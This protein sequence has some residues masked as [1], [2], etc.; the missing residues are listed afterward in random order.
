M[1]H[2]VWIF[3]GILALLKQ[4]CP[5]NNLPA[6]HTGPSQLDQALA[7]EGGKSPKASQA[8][9]PAASTPGAH[10][11]HSK[12]EVAQVNWCQDWVERRLA[13]VVKQNSALPLRLGA[14]VR[15]LPEG[16]PAATSV[17]PQEVRLYVSSIW[18]LDVNTY[19]C[20]VIIHSSCLASIWH[21]RLCWL[22]CHVRAGGGGLQQ[23][24]QTQLLHCLQESAGSAGRG[25]RSPG[26]SQAAA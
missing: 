14:L 16:P 7:A 13:V 24:L 22:P 8:G 25:T 19:G 26:R 4:L 20:V 5:A 12:Y 18:N 1:E 3:H 17:D 9:L 23:K 6:V 2:A 11:G 10:L 15:A 21:V